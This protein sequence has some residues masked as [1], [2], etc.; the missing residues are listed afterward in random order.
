MLPMDFQSFALTNDYTVNPAGM[1]YFTYGLLINGHGNKTSAVEAFENI[2][3]YSLTTQRH[4]QLRFPKM[5]A[6]SFAYTYI[7]TVK[8]LQYL[9]H[10]P[11]AKF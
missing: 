7:D 1:Q 8:F 2:Y 5:S 3:G 10:F 4:T 9:R 6:T 11:A